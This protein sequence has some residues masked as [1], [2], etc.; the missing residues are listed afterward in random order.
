MNRFH[1]KVQ[2]LF[3]RIMCLLNR[4]LDTFL[5]FPLVLYRGGRGDDVT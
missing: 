5:V 2:Q 3:A 1:L 4:G